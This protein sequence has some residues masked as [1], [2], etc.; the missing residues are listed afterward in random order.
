M[1]CKGWMAGEQKFYLTIFNVFIVFN[2]FIVVMIGLISQDT[3]FT[4]MSGIF[5]YKRLT[6][7]YVC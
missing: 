3:R 5:L 7:K 4:N 1:L 2:I 6:M